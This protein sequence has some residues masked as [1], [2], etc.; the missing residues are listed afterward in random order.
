MLIL[1]VDPGLAGALALIDT[2]S[3]NLIV[4]DVPTTFVTRNGRAHGKARAVDRVELAR[5]IDDAQK[6][7]H[8]SHAFVEH[9]SSSP[10]MGVSSAFT[11]GRTYGEIL[12]VL[13]AHF[14]PTT[15]VTPPMWKA[16]LR[17]PRD[18]NGA[19]ARASE[20]MPQAS[21][22]WRLGKHDG[23]AEAAMI[24]YFGW[25]SLNIRGETV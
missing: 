12:G 7:T 22:L 17:V 5:W 21:N 6:P 25:Q 3:G 1:G 8:I 19:R 2:K 10:Q 13:S 16:A 11:F 23:R 15:F 9:V 24:A 20:L 14:I 4:Q 18:K